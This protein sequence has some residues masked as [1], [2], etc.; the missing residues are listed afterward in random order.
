MQHHAD[1]DDADDDDDDDDDDEGRISDRAAPY[2]RRRAAG[3]A[4]VPPQTHGRSRSKSSS[5]VTAA[6]AAC[7]SSSSPRSVNFA[8]GRIGREPDSSLKSTSHDSQP[9]SGET[10]G[11]DRRRRRGGVRRLRHLPMRAFDDKAEAASADLAIE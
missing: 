5:S 2:T 6:A 10:S 11:I 9:A 7:I 3:H 8:E 1:D 4:R